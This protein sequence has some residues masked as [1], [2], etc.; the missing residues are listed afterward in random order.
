MAHKG[1]RRRIENAFRRLAGKAAP[2]S[3]RKQLM[4]ILILLIII[5]AITISLISYALSRQVIQEKSIR[6][7]VDIL[8]EVT[9]SIDRLL[10]EIDSMSVMFCYNDNIQSY[11]KEFNNR[12]ESIKT[13]GDLQQNNL[14]RRKLLQELFNSTVAS[15][16]VANPTLFTYNYII[17]SN[18]VSR[19]TVTQLNYTQADIEKLQAGK[20]ALVWTTDDSQPPKILF[21]REINDLS[22]QKPIGYFM[23]NYSTETLN[24]M[25]ADVTYFS[26]GYLH[27]I[28]E[29][30]RIIASNRRNHLG[31]IFEYE[32][33]LDAEKKSFYITDTRMYAS[34]CNVPNTD[35]RLVSIIPSVYYESEV[36]HL[37]IYMLVIA[38]LSAAIAILLAWIFAR[39]IVNPILELCRQMTSVGDG[40]FEVRRPVKQRN[41]IGM[42][43]RFFYQM[44]DRVQMLI[45][46]NESQQLLIQKA[47]LNSLRMQINPHFIYN[48]LESI[49]WIAHLNGNN[50]IV[51]MVKALGDFMRSSINGS[52]FVTLRTEMTNIENYLT[53]QKYRYGDRLMTVI[54][55]PDEMEY[56]QIPKL[57]L[58][59]LIENA[60]VHGLEQKVGL[61]CINMHAWRDGEDA[62]IAI[63]DD[64]IGISKEIMMELDLD[65]ADMSPH[66]GGIGMRNVHQRIR[67]YYGTEYG[68]MIESKF[69]LETTITVH[70][71][72]NT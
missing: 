39:R 71:P 31:D 18:N 53:I 9:N 51:V 64:G 28:D 42:L 58:Q 60:I 56:L 5:P 65:S 69:G 19:V 14:L 32:A 54:D 37:L 16:A 47:E 3:I 12:A 45:D 63:K 40:D 66:S 15:T 48:T 25:L 57:I 50:D 55:V 20:G 68:L 27:L 26:E 38:C 17:F 44:I 59:P 49:K 24:T 8:M 52:E 29:N 33:A 70:I 61:G 13:I 6:Y 10:D 35:W 46:Q 67:M 11:M 2:V 21:G 43:Y 30:G 34:Y 62:Y 23:G 22:T 36:H 41:E 4:A 1:K 72:Y 7:N